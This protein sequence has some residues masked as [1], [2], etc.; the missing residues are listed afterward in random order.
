MGSW[1]FKKLK[2]NNF[3]IIRARLKCV[4][5]T[6]IVLVFLD[7]IFTTFSPCLKI[8]F[9]LKDREKMMETFFIFHKKF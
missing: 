1:S 3:C 4:G 6:L 2:K 9:N 7:Y 5:T 8:S